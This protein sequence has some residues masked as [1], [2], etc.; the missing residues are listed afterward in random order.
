M[1]ETLEQ[2][3]VRTAREIKRRTAAR[4]ARLRA[5][6]ESSGLERKRRAQA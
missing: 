2:L 6:E 1:P 3:K 5:E 4:I